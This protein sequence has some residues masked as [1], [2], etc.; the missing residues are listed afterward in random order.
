MRVTQILIVENRKLD[1]Y[2][3]CHDHRSI[4]H[5][6]VCFG[7]G[8]QGAHIGVTNIRKYTKCQLETKSELSSRSVYSTV[9]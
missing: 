1:I 9:D 6:P 7:L 3:C 4:G 2:Y 5:I 8:M